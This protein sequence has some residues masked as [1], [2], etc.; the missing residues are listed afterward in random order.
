[1]FDFGRQWYWAKDCPEVR[2][3]TDL[4][5]VCVSGI[6]LQWLW[7]SLFPPISIINPAKTSVKHTGGGWVIFLSCFWLFVAVPPPPPPRP[8]GGGEGGGRVP[9]SRTSEAD[10]NSRI[11]FPQLY[12]ADGLCEC[13]CIYEHYT[14]FQ[15]IYS[16]GAILTLGGEHLTYLMSVEY[17]TA[18]AND[19]TIP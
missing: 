2:K 12:Y 6:G 14:I 5:C 17:R 11:S 3:L 8:M 10:W 18:C 7:C 19:R 13:T 9:S 1:M 4:G 16:S 15:L